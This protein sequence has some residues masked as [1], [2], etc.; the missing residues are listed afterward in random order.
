MGKEANRKFELSC[1]TNQ[2]PRARPRTPLLELTDCRGRQ[3]VNFISQLTLGPAAAG[4]R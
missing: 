4:P 3:F 2:S 1:Q